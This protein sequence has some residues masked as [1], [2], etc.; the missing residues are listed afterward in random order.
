MP[1][2]LYLI[3][4]LPREA[5]FQHWVVTNRKARKTHWCSQCQ[6]LIAKGQ[7]YCEVVVG[8]SGLEGLKFPTRL[9][10]SCL[11]NYL[12]KDNYIVE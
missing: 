12:E 5:P 6:E 9:H 4:E 8:G 2:E 10:S 11:S 7:E 3:K 1:K